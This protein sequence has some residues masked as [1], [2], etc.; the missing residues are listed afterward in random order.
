MKRLS[1][2]MI[3]IVVLSTLLAACGG[4]AAAS[5]PA[6]VVK[7]AMAA[8]TEKNFDKLSEFVC[9]AQKDKVAQSFNPAGALASAGVDPKKILDA[10]TIKLENGEFIKTSESG[11]KAEVQMKGKLTI[12]VDRE[13]FKAVMM[14]IAKA[15][16]Q[17]LPADQMDP[18][19][20]MVIG[21][22][23]QGIDLDEKVA[24]VKEGGKWLMCP[25]N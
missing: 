7:S 14:E 17:E 13:K 9:A 5:D 24:V 19:L 15:Q 21:Q 3:V 6:G 11:D 8:V 18:V 22:F 16:G 20:D 2:V 12:S 4:G 23:S 1:V 25:E 10:M